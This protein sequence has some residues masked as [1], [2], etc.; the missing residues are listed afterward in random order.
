MSF[1]FSDFQRNRGPRYNAQLVRGEGVLCAL[2][3]TCP[4][5]K[6]LK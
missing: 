2:D 4:L 5:T 6:T 3:T 1:V